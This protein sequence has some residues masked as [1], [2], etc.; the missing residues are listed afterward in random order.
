MVVLVTLQ[1]KRPEQGRK[2]SRGPLLTLDAVT[3]QVWF[4]F[5]RTTDVNPTYMGKVVGPFASGIGVFTYT[6]AA[7]TLTATALYRSYALYIQGTAEYNTL[8]T[9]ATVKTKLC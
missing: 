7:P 5:G 2:Q 1:C 6:V 3:T 9:D 8:G 4:Y